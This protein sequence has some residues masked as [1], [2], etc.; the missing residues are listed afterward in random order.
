M[1][2][3]KQGLLI[4]GKQSV[5]KLSVLSESIIRVQRQM[6]NQSA[7]EELILTNPLPEYE[8]WS[9][10]ETPDFITVETPAIR[11]VYSRADSTL[12]FCDCAFGKIIL[13]EK[14]TR[15]TMTSQENG[16]TGHVE[17][18]FWSDENE[19][20]GGLGQQADGVCNY[21]GRFVHLNQFNIISAVPVLISGNGYGLLWNN[22]SL[23]EINRKKTPLKLDFHPYTKTFGTV[24]VPRQTGQYIWII[25]KLTKNMGYE[26]L[27]VRV[28]DTVVIERGTSWH[29]N[30]YTGSIRLEA[31]KE[32]S[33]F[34][35]A[36]VNL[37]YQTPN[38]Q[39]ETSIWSEVGGGIDY[40]VLYG[41]EADQIIQGYRRLTGDAPL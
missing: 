8:D 29:A 10:K 33:V 6:D 22:C 39:E 12:Q 9:V 14:E 18:S 32:Y 30:Y 24:F 28:G 35:N 16:W 40:C 11:A 17:Q 19:I 5:L 37:Y 21:K 2:K 34:V 1:K 3:T 7:P 38:Q 36:A 15:F 20:L 41:P 27:V 26:N 4:E 13:R 25:E 31:G 23:T